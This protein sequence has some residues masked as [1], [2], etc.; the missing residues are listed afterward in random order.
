MKWFLIFVP[1]TAILNWNGATP[2]WVFCSALIAIPPLVELLGSATDRLSVQLGASIGGFLS[3][4]LANA[5][6]LIIGL[7][8]LKNGLASVVKA[9]LT[10]SILVNLLVG[11]GCALVVGGMKFGVRKFERK[12]LRVNA[13]ML[14]LCSFCFIVP[15]VFQS[16]V[17]DAS[18][19]LSTEIALIL[20]LVYIINIVYTLNHQPI[21]ASLRTSVSQVTEKI[22][23]SRALVQLGIA[24]LGLAFTSDLLTE[25][26]QPMAQGLGLSDV[27]SGVVLLGGVGGCGEVLTALRFAKAGKQELVLA[28]TVGSTIQMVLLVAPLLVLLGPLVGQPMDLAFSSIEVIAIVISVIVTRELINDGKVTW[29]EG[30]LLLATY[31]IFAFAFY[32]VPESYLYSF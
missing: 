29:M 9:S 30:V 27:F 1:I 13:A 2:L 11:L 17:P 5:P 22:S 25:S 23:I 24:A 7:A 26:L 3:A 8:G 21:N 32:H 4:T 14:M 6:E 15:A 19:E 20:L 18:R 31:A 10:G 12:Y 28:V 16:V